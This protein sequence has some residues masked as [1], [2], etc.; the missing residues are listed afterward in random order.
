VS[1]S[2]PTK[3]ELAAAAKRSAA[4]KKG[5]ETKRQ[6]AAAEKAKAETRKRA[7][8]KAAATRKANAAKAKRSAAAKKGA[9]TRKRKA[10]EAAAAKEK[11]KT[12]AKKGAETKRLKAAEKAKAEGRPVRPNLTT[13]HAGIDYKKKTS[14]HGKTNL[15]VELTVKA[16]KDLVK[17][18]D[19]NRVLQHYAQTG[20]LPP[21]VY[22]VQ[23]LSWQHEHH[24]KQEPAD[25]FEQE[26]VRR[27]M[28]TRI[29]PTGDFYEVG[30]GEGGSK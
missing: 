30:R 2:R 12:A 15:H 18:E 23:L 20:E 26:E 29:A 17:P 14:A 21:G 11:R 6:K 7:A 5:A 10:A 25:E 28:L 3:A 8:A 27:D 9:E 1:K 24:A 22:D 4:A 13:Y 19:L 16:D